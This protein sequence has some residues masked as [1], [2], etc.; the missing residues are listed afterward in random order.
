MGLIKREKTEQTAE[1]RENIRNRENLLEQL[2][3]PEFLQR[4]MAA[5]DL[6][7]FSGIS[8]Q[9]C[10]RLNIE[11]HPAVRAAIFSSLTQIHDE[12]SMRCL[13]DL[14]RSEDPE[15]RNSSIEA[16]IQLPDQLNTEI[17]SLLIDEDAD[18]RIFAINI[19]EG[20]PHPSV[21]LWL[22]QVIINEQNVNVCSVAV[23]LL[24]ELGT[25]NMIPDLIALKARFPDTPFIEMAVDLTVDRINS[26][27]FVGLSTFT[28]ADNV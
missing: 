9:L 19:L 27:S 15:L 17:E 1:R 6:A 16:L 20:L 10:Q 12:E 4:R 23:D 28:A 14:L 3:D 18:V 22:H 25:P 21:P 11:Q 24:T 26:S 2:N 5:H 7:E 8:G 13:I